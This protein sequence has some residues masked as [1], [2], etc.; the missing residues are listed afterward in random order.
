M[1]QKLLFIIQD[2]VKNTGAG[3]LVVRNKIPSGIHLVGPSEGGI[4]FELFFF[5]TLTS[6]TSHPIADAF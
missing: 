3:L 6:L 1:S 5:V 4:W 2:A